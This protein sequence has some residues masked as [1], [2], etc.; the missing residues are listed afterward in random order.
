MKIK[1]LFINQTQAGWIGDGLEEYVG[2]L[3][4]Y[5]PL[6]I[7][8]VNSPMRSGKSKDNVVKEEGEKVLSLLKSTDKLVLLDESG[9]EMNSVQLSVW[10]NKKMVAMNGDLVMLVGGAYG[11]SD[12]IVDRALEKISLSKLTFTHQMVRIILVE[13]LYRA[14]TIL[15]NEPYHHS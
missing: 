13:Q 7:R 14:M 8:E 1:L 15:R 2:R 10:L 11:F 5:L 9:A 12:E 6:E 3:K 4:R